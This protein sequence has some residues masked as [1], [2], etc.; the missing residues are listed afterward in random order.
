MA[1][2]ESSTLSLLEIQGAESTTV[3]APLQQK[4]KYHPREP[5]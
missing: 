5:G 2:L 4:K 1:P 3:A